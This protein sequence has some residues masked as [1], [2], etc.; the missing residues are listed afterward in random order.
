MYTTYCS[1]KSDL[2]TISIPQEIKIKSVNAARRVISVQYMQKFLILERQKH[3]E[4]KKPT[5]H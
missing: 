4:E 5:T 2:Q 3:V 1:G